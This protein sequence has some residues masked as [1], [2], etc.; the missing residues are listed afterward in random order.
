MTARRGRTGRRFSARPGRR[1]VTLVSAAIAL[2]CALGLAGL[3]VA[4]AAGSHPAAKPRSASA[5]SNKLLA[6]ERVKKIC[7][8]AAWRALPL[9]NADP[10][11]A[12]LLTEAQAL[13][14]VGWKSGDTVGAA[15]MTYGQAQ[16]AYPSVASSAFINRSRA[17]WIITLHLAAPVRGT[18]LD[19]APGAKVPMISAATFVIDAATGDE[20]DWCA[21]CS[22]IAASA[23][24]TQI[25]RSEG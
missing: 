7:N 2:P 6:C 10:A 24:A 8:P 22:T 25:A 15:K 20:T 1:P 11:G 12:T 19:L 3:G 9:R 21:G 17:V 16:A 18:S 23:S 13:A 5:I 4:L 14:A